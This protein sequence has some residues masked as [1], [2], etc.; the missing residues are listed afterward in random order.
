MRV[1]SQKASSIPTRMRSAA[2]CLFVPLTLEAMNPFLA[3]VAL[4]ADVVHLELVVLN[5]EI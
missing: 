4:T 2:S 5:F 1:D 3:L